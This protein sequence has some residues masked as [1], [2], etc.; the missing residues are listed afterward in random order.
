MRTI[1]FRGR[2]K[3]NEVW[4][5]GNYFDSKYVTTGTIVDDESNFNIDIDKSTLGQ[6]TGLF[7]KNGN[8]IYEGD[9]VS[10][11]YGQMLVYFGKIVCEG[12][13]F[14]WK[15]INEDSSKESITGFID[16]Y[17]VIGNIHDNPELLKF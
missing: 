15:P 3:H 1:K 8:E 5:F 11:A 12:Y 16:E 2:A 4:Y 10:G 6:F 9:I 13:G 14:Q 7:D 17:E